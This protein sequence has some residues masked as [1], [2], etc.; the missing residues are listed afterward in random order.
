MARAAALPVRPA[1]PSLRRLAPS[2]RSLLVGFALLALGVGSFLV[3]RDTSL[4][5]VQRLVVVGGPAATQAEVR[6]ALAGER[7]RSLLLVNGDEI[8][9][10]IAS[11]ANVVSVSFDRDFPH[12]LRVRVHAERPVLLLRR[13]AEGF[14]VSARGRVLSK[15]RNVHLSPLPRIWVSRTTDFGI[16]DLL[17]PAQGGRAAAALASVRP[18]LSGRIRVVR[19]ERGDLTFLMR[20]GLELRLGGIDDIRLKLA[21]A[22]RIL[23]LIGPVAAGSYLDVSVPER[24]VVHTS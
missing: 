15:V 20:S 7:G 23:P 13:G 5:A 9:R 12:T 22:R 8:D 21:I 6:A 18:P 3:A 4:F 10:R 2:G 17:G 11:L 16:G 14:V 24:P 19:V 1:A